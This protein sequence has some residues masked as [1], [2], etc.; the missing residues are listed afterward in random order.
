M[1]S[2]LQTLQVGCQVDELLVPNKNLP[3]KSI[4]KLIWKNTIAYEMSCLDLKG[5]IKKL[6][7]NF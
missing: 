1:K 3:G 5:S 2:L 6:K 7:Y 4:E